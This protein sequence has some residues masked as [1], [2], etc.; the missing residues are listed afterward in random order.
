MAFVG[1]AWH[2]SEDEFQGFVD[3]HGLTFPQIS[4]DA[5][6]VFDRF[7]VP[8][9]PAWAV[10]TPDGEVSTLLGALDEER[11]DDVLSDATS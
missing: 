6:A 2:G 4:D 3:E 8:I 11:L 1:V 10:V 5:G 7:E 9:Q